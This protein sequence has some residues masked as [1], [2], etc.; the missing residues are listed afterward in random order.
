MLEFMSCARPVILGVDGQ[1]RIILEE[2]RSGLIIEPENV[3]ALANAI[4]SLAANRELARELGRS[5]REHILRKFSRRQTAEKY[6]RVLERMLKIPER[7]ETE[8]A[9]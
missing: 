8:I 7:G 9:A 4:Q 3:E 1:A 6:I 5:G 2:A